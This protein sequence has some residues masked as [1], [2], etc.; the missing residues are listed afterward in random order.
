M[1]RVTPIGVLKLPGVK[2]TL[3]FSARIVPSAYFVP[4][5]PKLP[6]MAIFVT[7]ARAASFFFA[8]LKYQRFTAA[9]MG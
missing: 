1:T 3:C 6:V 8:S 7:S 9:S 5:F 4:V 2:S